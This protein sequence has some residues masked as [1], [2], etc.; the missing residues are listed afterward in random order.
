[1]ERTVLQGPQ[2][3]FSHSFQAIGCL[4]GLMGLLEL[5]IEP[6]LACR[7]L[8]SL[9][10]VPSHQVMNGGNELR[11]SPDHIE[12]PTADV[13]GQ[14]VRQLESA[15]DRLRSMVIERENL[16]LS[17]CISEPQRLE[18]PFP[19]INAVT[20]N[21]CGRRFTLGSEDRGRPVCVPDV[22]Q[23]TV[24]RCHLCAALLIVNLSTNV[25]R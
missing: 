24:V 19:R 18:R 10:P 20:C 4:P 17:Q 1:M 13:T 7:L 14:A 11:H 3:Y 22:G 15:I 16:A 21:Y 6:A 2:R 23:M 9:S 12:Q 5:L 25:A 8:S